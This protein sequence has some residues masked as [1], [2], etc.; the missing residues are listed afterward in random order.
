MVGNGYP[1]G[2]RQKRSNLK[3]VGGRAAPALPEPSR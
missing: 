1:V 2:K 3:S